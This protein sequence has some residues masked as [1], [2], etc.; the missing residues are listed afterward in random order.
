MLVGLFVV[1]LALPAMAAAAP[2]NAKVGYELTYTG[3]IYIN[4][5]YSGFEANGGDCS[6]SPNDM[7]SP[8]NR[9]SHCAT[10]E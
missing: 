6:L 9:T 8:F 1:A 2:A 5:T 10:I 7:T 3:L 4:H